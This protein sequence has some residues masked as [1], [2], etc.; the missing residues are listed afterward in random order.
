MS[1][2]NPMPLRNEREVAR[3]LADIAAVK[4][5]R[6][7]YAPGFALEYIRLA[8]LAHGIEAIIHDFSTWCDDEPEARDARNP[9]G[10]Y[11]KAIDRRLRPQ[12]A[13]S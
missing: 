8:M 1:Q 12:A 3:R 7:T 2:Q 4:L 10:D 13:Q 6:V 5:H 9:I 11:V